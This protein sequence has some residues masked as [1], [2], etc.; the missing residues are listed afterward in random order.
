MRMLRVWLLG[1]RAVR[2]AADIALDVA[3][4][5]VE[6]EQRIVT[7]VTAEA[8]EIEARVDQACAAVRTALTDS[9]TPGFIDAQEAK[10]VTRAVI[11]VGLAAHDHNKT[12]SHLT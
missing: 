7:R 4:R 9:R 12:L 6:R 3:Q 8:V 5:Q 2:G 10:V 11:G 1:E